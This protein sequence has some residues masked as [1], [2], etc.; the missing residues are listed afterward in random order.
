MLIIARP[1]PSRPRPLSRP[2][3]LLLSNLA[4]LPS[5]DLCFLSPVSLLEHDVHS[6]TVVDH[7][8]VGQATEGG[9]GVVEETASRAGCLAPMLVHSGC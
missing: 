2:P 9:D 8:G 4:D 7:V 5:T 1:H 6:Q 3:T